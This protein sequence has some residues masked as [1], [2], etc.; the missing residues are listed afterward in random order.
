[1]LIGHYGAALAAK[2]IDPS[3]PLP[4]VMLGTQLIDVV[5][6]GLLLAGVEK[7]RMQ[8]GFTATTHFELVYIPYSHSLP[9]SVLISA[10]GAAGLAVL[11][12]E[13]SMTAL[14]VMFAVCLSHWFLD[15]LVHT[16]DLPLI[17]DRYKVGFGLW[18]NKPISM[19]LEF[20]IF[21]VG[22]ALF[23]GSLSAPQLEAAVIPISVVLGGLVA[24][25]FYVFFGP[26]VDSV[27]SLAITALVI[28]ALATVGGFWIEASY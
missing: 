12:P 23:I 19:V 26:P 1:M 28:Y 18:N 11:Y 3:V 4:A 7:V 14:A 20:G 27:P 5:W 6:A 10:L 21:A 24:L 2:A 25:Q 22:A 13:L 9:G 15:L 17:G 8:P 16:P